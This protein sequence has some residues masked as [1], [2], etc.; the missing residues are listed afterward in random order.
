MNQEE[1][2]EQVEKAVDGGADPVPA[3]PLK[4]APSPEVKPDATPEPAAPVDD[5]TALD[6]IKLKE[7]ID[8]LNI[9]L[10]QER[11]SK[12]TDSEEKSSRIKSLEDKLAKTSEMQEKLQNVFAP[13]PEPTPDAPSYMTK[14]EADAYWQEKEA[15]Q[16]QKEEMNKKADLISQEIKKMETEWN[17]ESGKPKYIDAD[18]LQWQQDVGKPY[19]SPE[20]AF[21]QMK[22]NEIIDWEAKQ[23]LAGKKATPPTETPSSV[24]GS[25]E[26][27]ESELKTDQDVRRAVEEAINA[28]DTE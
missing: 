3:D 24:P 8:N 14:E 4:D 11:E 27:V 22:K 23:I 28:V 2:R 16:V 7:Q 17:G 6:P 12:R 5:K 15:E 21:F 9:A 19:L 1:V 25:H 13:T 10:K 20:E 18:V 26:P